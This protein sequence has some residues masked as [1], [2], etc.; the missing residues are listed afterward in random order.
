MYLIS[1]K[2]FPFCNL[3]RNNGKIKTEFSLEFE[4]VE[5]LLK[6]YNFTVNF[7][8]G[9]DVWGV[10]EG[11]KWNGVIGH[12]LYGVSNFHINFFQN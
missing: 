2:V 5:L 7:V 4:L 10:E 6:K 3:V 9:N 1:F 11:G 8:D 12:V